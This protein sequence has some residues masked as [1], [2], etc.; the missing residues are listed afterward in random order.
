MNNSLIAT[1]TNNYI[2]E[3]NNCNT[4]ATNEIKLDLGKYG[5]ISIFLCK[6]CIPKF[7]NQVINK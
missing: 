6:N 7:T 4:E 3:A 1:T 2:C 5:Q